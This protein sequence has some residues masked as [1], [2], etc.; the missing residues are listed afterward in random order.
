MSKYKTPFK[1]LNTTLNFISIPSVSLSIKYTNL[2]YKLLWLT[3]QFHWRILRNI[4]DMLTVSLS[5]A[6]SNRRAD[7][8]RNRFWFFAFIIISPERLE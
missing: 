2:Q 5:E 7:I 1:I 4:L 3:Y 8:L 6:I